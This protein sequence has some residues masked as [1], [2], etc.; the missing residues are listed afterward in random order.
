MGLMLQA[1]LDL[2]WLLRVPPAWFPHQCL[3]S[4]ERLGFSLGSPRSFHRPRDQIGIEE[5]IP[6][7]ED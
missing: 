7:A 3:F 2:G 1:V 4:E 5:M 6:G